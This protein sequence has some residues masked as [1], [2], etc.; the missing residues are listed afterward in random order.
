MHAPSD[1]NRKNR[2]EEISP[3]FGDHPT[4]PPALEDQPEENIRIGAYQVIRRLGEGGMGT[5]YLSTRVDQ[6]FKKDVAIKV[7][8]KGMDTQEILARFKIERQI[9]AALDHPN[10]ARLF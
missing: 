8:R 3:I 6:E 2:K 10:I 5:V 4:D 9:L 7:I 1:N